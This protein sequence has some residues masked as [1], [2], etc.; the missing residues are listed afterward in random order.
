M[1]VSGAGLGI[2]RDIA[3]RAMR[4]RHLEPEFSR[5]ALREVEGIDR[6]A[7]GAGEDIR[8]LRGLLWASIDNDDSRDLDQISVAEP[9]PGSSLKVLVAVADVDALVTRGSP[10]D[11]HARVNTTSVYTVAQI[12]P[13]LPEK[14]STDLTSLAENRERLA[15]VIEMTV[16][17]AGDIAAS[18]IYRGV[19]VNRAKLAYDGVSAWLEGTG[20]APERVAAV[21]GLEEQLRMQDQAA[22]RLRQVRHM[23]GALSLASSEAIPVFDGEVL[24]DLRPEESN[25][26]KELIEDFMIAANGVTAQ[27]LSDR[28]L[29]SL[30]RVL[31]T[32]ER[33]GRIAALA[34]EHGDRLPPVASAQALNQ[35]LLRRRRADPASFP[36]LCLAVIKLLGR[37]EYVLQRPGAAVEGHF[38]L[39]VSDYTHA[40]APNRRF[41]DLISHR[42][43]KQALRGGPAPYSEGELRAL[44]AHCT[45]QED[46]AAK[47]ERRLRKSA[48]ALLLSSRVG[49]RFDAV[50]TGAGE[51]G[52]WVRIT[53]PTA[54]GK[55]IR[56]FGGLDVGHHVHVALV[57]TDVAQGFIDF[58]LAR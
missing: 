21:S 56:G 54:E 42:L 49:Q 38:G 19:V 3:R 11:E 37:G 55:L 17:A 2:L 20:P 31:R 15:I 9:L 47:V 10:I 8:D 18:D 44:A 13:M 6:A 51:Q 57:H 22:Q 27:Y 1:S 36:D 48:A 4:E 45:E 53:S 5:E 39:A 41:P 58:E 28:G 46:N 43:L 50:I 30:R 34:S 52:T 40:T 32:P 12:F 35:F 16:G 29:P 23:H 26:A 7:T 14:L 24:R 25:R 33:W